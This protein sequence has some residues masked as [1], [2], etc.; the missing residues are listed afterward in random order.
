MEW[1]FFALLEDSGHRGERDTNRLCMAA[2]PEYDPLGV[3]GDTEIIKPRERQMYPQ[4]KNH[5]VDADTSLCPRKGLVN[6]GRV[7]CLRAANVEGC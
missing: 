5:A 6:A 7:V 2:S 4:G 3:Q 1:L